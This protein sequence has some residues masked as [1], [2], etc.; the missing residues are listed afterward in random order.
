MPNKIAV[1]GMACRY[2]G[3]NSL[4]EYWSNLI[5]GK[6]TIR[7]FSDEELAEFEYNFD[8]LKNNPDFVKAKGILDDVDKFDASFFGMT[9]AE[10]AG[11]DPQHR[12][13]L[14]TAWQALENA[15]CDPFSYKG[16]I[17]VFAGGTM[18]TYLLNNVLRGQ[19]KMENFIRFRSPDAY[20]ITTGNDPSYI[21]TKTAYKFNLRGP[22]IN[23]QTAC[24]TSLVAISQACQSLY[25][26]ESDICLAGGVCITIPQETGYIYQEGA[27]P[28]PDGYCRPFD[29]MAKGTVPGNGVGAVVLK[30]LEDAE[31]DGD[32]IYAV[33]R[34][35][36]LNND[37]NNKVSFTAPSVDG[38][39]EVIMMAQAFAEVSPDEIG[40]IE[41]HGTATQLGDPIEI[42]GL[43]KAFSRKT[44]RKQF[45]GIGSVKSNIGH[46]DVAAGVASFIKVCLSA[47]H[48]KIPAS[49]NFSKPNPH[50]DFENTPFYVLDHLKEW[51]RKE[52]MIMG[53]SSF[54]IG[55]TNAHVIVEEPPVPEKTMEPKAE[56]PQLLV[57]S[58]KSEYSLDKRKQDLVEFLKAGKELHING[59]ANTLAYGRS[60][61]QYRSFTVASEVKDVISDQ[62]VFT[63]GRAVSQ[64]SKIAFLFPGQGAQ[65]VQMGMD[66]YNKNQSFRK[67]LDEC[68]EIYRQET[69][70]DIK[71]LIFNDITDSSE[72][73]LART[74]LA[75]PALFIIEYALAK[76]LEE[77]DIKPDYLIGHSIGEYSAAC[78]A[79]V[80]DLPTALRI[81]IKRG[82]LMGRMPSGKMMAV[83][84]NVEKLEPLKTGCFEI[85]ADNASTACT[86]SF[87]PENAEKVQKLLEEN[88]IPFIPLNTSHAFHS[89][90]FDPILSEFADYV[91]QFSLKNPDKPFIS[92]LTGSYITNSQATDGAYWAQQ[93]RNTVLFSKG[94]SEIA[95]NEGTVFL[96]V[97]PNTHISSL[98]KQSGDIKDKKLIISTLGK[99][100][101]ADERYKI[102]AAL[103]HLFNVGYK[104]NFNAFYGQGKQQKMALPVYPFE[105]KRHWI[106]YRPSGVINEDD[107]A[108]EGSKGNPII[109]DL[110][111]PEGQETTLAA[112]SIADKVA[113]IWKQLIGIDRIDFD[114]D[115]FELGG[116]SL[117]ALQIIT[118][119]KEE[120]GIKV[121]LKEFLDN[122]TVN[123][124]CSGFS[125]EEKKPEPVEKSVQKI[126]LENYP[127]SFMQKSIWIVS[128]LD[129][130]NPAYNIPFTFKLTGEIN[131]NIFR[132]SLDVLFN[133]HFIV[134][135]LFK[136]K[137]GIP[138]CFIRPKP[139]EVEMHDFSGKNIERSIKEI[140]ESIGQA[141]RKCFNLES[142]PLYKLH[143]YKLNDSNYYFHCTFH[144]MVF[145]G[146][147]YSIFLNDL[148]SIYNSLSLNKELELEDI[149][150]CYLDYAE[151][152]QREGDNPFNRESEDF[153]INSLKGCLSKLEF[154]YDYPRKETASGFGE[155][156]RIQIPL[157]VT[158]K[159]K[160]IAREEHATPFAV[161]LSLMGILFHRYSGETDICIGT[162][163]AN[164]PMSSLEKIFGMFVNT[165]P[166]RLNIDRD[167][168]L[169]SYIRDVRN[170]LLE[171]LTH[172]E[173]PFE[174]IVELVRPERFLNVNPIFQMAVQWITYSAKPVDFNGFSAERV[175]VKEIVSPL[176]MT[177]NLWENEEL[178]EG[179]VE[180]NID[181]LKQSTVTS[182]VENFIELIQSAVDNSD[183][184][185]SDLSIISDNDKKMLNEFNHTNVPLPDCL[186]QDLVEQQAKRYPS[187]VAAICGDSKLTYKELSEKSDKLA[188]Y[189]ISHG[190]KPGEVVGIYMERSVEMIVSVLGILK[191]GCCYLPMDPSFPRERLAFMIEDSGANVL[192]TQSS[193]KENARGF[194]VSLEVFTDEE[195]AKIN[196]GNAGNLKVT[197]TPEF[198]AYIIYTSGSTGKPKGV[199]VHHRGVVNFLLSMKTNPGFSREDRLLAVTTLSFDIS[200]LEIFLPLSNGAQVIVAVPEDITDGQR[201][202][203]LISRHDITVMQATP[204]TWNLLLEEGWK[205]KKN[206]K[207]LCGG[208]ALTPT[209][210]QKLI[211]RVKTLW[212]MYGPTETTVWSTCYQITDSEAPI[213]VGRPINN[214]TVY[215]LDDTNRELPVG[216]IGE[217]GIGGDGVTKG[218][219]NRPELN[220][221]K[222]VQLDSKG[223]V[224]KTGDLG[225]YLYDGNIELFGRIDNQVKLRGFRIEL[226]EIENQLMKVPEI[227]DVVVKLCKVEENDFRLIAFIV[228]DTK[229]K[230]SK[231]KIIEQISRELPSYMLPSLFQVYKELPRLPNGKTD[232]KALKFDKSD[233]L[234][235]DIEINEV[236]SPT[237]SV[238]YSIW[239]K[240]L[241]HENISVNDN[242]FDLGGDSLKAVTLMAR[243]KSELKVDLPLKALLKAPR[244]KELA[245]SVESLLQK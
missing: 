63:D 42:A 71:S 139:V 10:A 66:L 147:S 105:N 1:I 231:T 89:A 134:F 23:V 31:R 80:F 201:L 211:P 107:S 174:K 178:I 215:I 119:L 95:K 104:V 141:S 90:A 38:Q 223:I 140:Y 199:K 98:A 106:D 14:Q 229:E 189:L 177:F 70:E 117:L 126:D 237:E 184:K 28:S 173:L 150:E 154:P 233:L 245:E 176:D 85:A 9:P 156:V 218:Y 102:V 48:K 13:W 125:L 219:H 99:I 5:S 124:L 7:H 3:A 165:I 244:I 143:L 53:V 2:P 168:T 68:F 75:Q 208:E 46:T 228:T 130:A 43:T 180:Y 96:E 133:R 121:T 171:S 100:D 131:I 19:K 227:K 206:M 220:A 169:R 158:A 239:C 20:Q 62:N 88:G 232:K 241:K 213:L 12:I 86:I 142:G 41:A 79:G 193:L 33:V 30:R 50:I 195:K 91:N 148:K 164:R 127:L 49:L 122:P 18:S 61:M 58:A 203:K 163:V 40:Y 76:L 60:F 115:F 120:L 157:E 194:K 145:D 118:R 183:Q 155:K 8:L 207:A 25:S 175:E 22:A 44:T 26:F 45:C 240:I 123:K 136:E 6:N 29:A 103:G 37:G 236:L 216:V 64:P 205:G 57:L 59:V 15:G 112:S 238:I 132:K 230:L 67:I 202:E 190:V 77:L 192:I 235:S 113:L 221:E 160:K 35:W 170:V 39:A 138:Y 214:T 159:I 78:L 242:F 87:T 84:A 116:H 152:L 198:L 204:A 186:I 224:Y 166:I 210:A 94:L 161:M 93:L 65:Y 137:D 234:D 16:A 212:N 187:S 209:L 128:K 217:V 108:A 167:Q 36:A 74:E 197:M 222:F 129:V 200:V 110:S 226:G 21:S 4:D 181:V 185:I 82:Q 179:E 83:R 51:T 73:N 32:V 101:N 81:V 52:P 182:M 27:I 135:S 56:W 109:K 146:W 114:D 144:H 243:I 69:N 11:T 162:H 153:W 54:G 55:G 111:S 188:S 149:K 24:S 151:E 225:R 72:S 47:Y 34:G 92:C 172:Q 196:A 17:G 97:G 191:A